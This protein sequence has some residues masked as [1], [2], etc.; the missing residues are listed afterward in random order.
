MTAANRKVYF[1]LQLPTSDERAENVSFPKP[2]SLQSTSSI[3]GPDEY[4]LR[5]NLSRVYVVAVC[6]KV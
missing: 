6:E 1:S 2:I 5:L 4:F 3:D